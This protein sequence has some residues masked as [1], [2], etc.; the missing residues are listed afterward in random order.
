MSR[1]NQKIA[2]YEEIVECTPEN[3]IKNIVGFIGILLSIVMIST[4]CITALGVFLTARSLYAITS[5][6]NEIF[7]SVKNFM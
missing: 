6:Q 7:V 1:Q 4:L 5:G 3:I 2:V